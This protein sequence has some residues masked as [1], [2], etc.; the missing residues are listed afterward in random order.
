VSSSCTTI[1]YDPLYGGLFDQQY[2]E[3]DSEVLDYEVR[4]HH[5]KFTANRVEYLSA[6]KKVQHQYREEHRNDLPLESRTLAWLL[7][8][9]PD[10]HLVVGMRNAEDLHR[11]L[12]AQAIDG[13]GDDRL[14][15][16]IRSVWEE[17][18][19]P[20]FV[21]PPPLLPRHSFERHVL[22]GHIRW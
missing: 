11:A 16:A 9:G 22:S 7:N 3:V 14:R 13:D 17:Q 12:R 4:R 2:A 21:T 15:N 10:R 6:L 18:G 19:T 8:E 1:G 20:E 5:P